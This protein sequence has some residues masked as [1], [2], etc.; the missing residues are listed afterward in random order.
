MS[1]ISDDDALEFDA[2]GLRGQV[3]LHLRGLK[4]E[5]LSKYLIEVRSVIVPNR[6]NVFRKD[7]AREVHT[8]D[9][10]ILETEFEEELLG[11]GFLMRRDS[12][13]R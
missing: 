8:K 9:V 4:F 11:I 7:E 3:A 10:E 13:R 2:E 1:W 5:Y 6:A 12:K